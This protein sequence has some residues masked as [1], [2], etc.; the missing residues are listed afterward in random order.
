METS[1]LE[2][3][4]GMQLLSKRPAWE[5]YLTSPRKEEAADCCSAS[6]AVPSSL[7]EGPLTQLSEAGKAFLGGHSAVNVIHR[8]TE[9]S[10]K[11]EVRFL[12]LFR[13]LGKY[14]HIFER[15]SLTRE[16][17]YAGFRNKPSLSFS[18]RIICSSELLKGKVF[19]HIVLLF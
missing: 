17:V 14:W 5:G 18:S 8:V 13:K 3:L 7:A 12:I 15:F 2:E 9:P 11:C 19:E 10:N 4:E 6:R 16:N 1:I